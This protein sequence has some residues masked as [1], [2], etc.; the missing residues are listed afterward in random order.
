MR[1][2]TAR[3]ANTAA[4]TSISL[5]QDGSGGFLAGSIV[6]LCV[7]DE[8]YN[9]NEQILGSAGVLTVS[10]IAADIGDLVQ[11]GNLKSTQAAISD[12]YKI[13]FN[14]DA[15]ATNYNRQYIRGIGAAVV[16]QTASNSDFGVVTGTHADVPTSAFGAYVGQVTNYSDGSNDRAFTG[17]SGVIYNAWSNY[18]QVKTAAIRWNNTA[19]I[20]TVQLENTYAANWSTGSMLSTYAVP[21]NLIERQELTAET[22]T[23]TSVTF[24]SIPGTYDHLELT[25]YARTDGGVTRRDIICSV[26]ADTTNS[27]YVLQALDG[28]SSTVSAFPNTGSSNTARYIARLTGNTA[29]ANAFGSSTTTFYNY[30]K[31]DRHKHY[32]SNSG[33]LPDNPYVRVS[34][35]RFESTAAITS[36]VI[37]AESGDDF[38]VGSVFTLRGINAPAAAG[39]SDVAKLNGIE[40][41]DI[42]E[43]N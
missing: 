18:A 15:T 29:T 16:S 38:M 33:N 2:G 4:I 5:S 14:T 35:S 11:I 43:V 7:V 13:K 3:W 32:L 23:A 39:T 37:T 31:T 20:T 27:N 9:I 6:E 42:A 41:S 24:S 19:A 8:S 28:D 21:K 40:T 34:S 26:N 12:E 1:I 36:L 10:S 25:M 17:L 22:G 30:T